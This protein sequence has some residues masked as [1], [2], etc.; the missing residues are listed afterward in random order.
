MPDFGDNLSLGDKWN[1]LIDTTYNFYKTTQCTETGVVPNW[2]LVKEVSNSSLEK[3][4]GSFSGS[5][6]PQYEFGAE[7][8]RTLWRVAFDA[9]LYPEESFEQT[10]LFLQPI[11]QKLKD[12]FNDGVNNWYDNALQGC[13]YVSNIFSSWRNNGFI[14][15]PVYST[16]VVQAQS[17]SKSHQQNLVNA[18]CGLIENMPTSY[19]ARSWQVIGMMTLNGDMEKV[20]NLL[21]DTGTS[22]IPTRTPSK[23]PTSNGKCKKTCATSSKPWKKLCKS[24]KCSA[25]PECTIGNQPT[26]SPTPTKTPVKPPVSQNDFCCT[27][28]FYHCGNSAWCNESMKNCQA[29]CS[30]GTWM[31][32]SAPEMQCIAKWGTCTA[33]NSGC[34]T[35]LT[36][37]GN[38]YYKQC[39]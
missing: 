28:D 26:R 32:K 2:A 6:T 5:G 12:N 8:S 10:R 21:R 29:G 38:N 35:G 18:A 24:L 20:G 14:F 34:C 22:Q 31:E 9:A 39:I 1:M 13:E 7:A 4:I 3:Q 19:Y 16:L 27:W 17:M 33:D 36:C 25:C 11:H 23:T 15:A 37:E 30:G